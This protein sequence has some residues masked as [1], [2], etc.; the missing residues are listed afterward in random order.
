[1][2]VKRRRGKGV[3]YSYLLD[4]ETNNTKLLDLCRI[5][6]VTDFTQYVVSEQ[7]VANRR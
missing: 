5:V 7:L 2:E 1:V 4:S 6:L 3:R